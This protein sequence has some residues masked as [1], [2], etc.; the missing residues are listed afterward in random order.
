MTIH[1]IDITVRSK[2]ATV[3]A[4]AFTVQPSR[5]GVGP[6]VCFNHPL[7]F[8]RIPRVIVRENVEAGAGLDLGAG[9]S[10]SADE[11]RDIL[12]AIDAGEV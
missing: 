8:V 10:V 1:G 4:L 5:W 7:F 11:L 2:G 9:W 12:R 3:A 6:V